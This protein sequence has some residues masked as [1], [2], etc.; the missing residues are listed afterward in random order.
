MNNS[1]ALQL[2]K[3]AHVTMKDML[4]HD[5]K[6]PMLDWDAIDVAFKT[7]SKPSNEKRGK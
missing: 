7:L 3:Q 2:I 1:D 6:Y 4:K 5:G